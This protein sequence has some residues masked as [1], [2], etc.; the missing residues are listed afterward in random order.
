MLYLFAVTEDQHRRV[1][2][3]TEKRRAMGRLGHRQLQQAFK[4]VFACGGIV[5]VRT[6]DKLQQSNNG[7]QHAGP[8]Q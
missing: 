6:H 5:M 7:A 8:R 3:L 2:Q 4:F 1:E